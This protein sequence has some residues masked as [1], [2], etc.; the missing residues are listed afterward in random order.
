MKQSYWSSTKIWIIKIFLISFGKRIMNLTHWFQTRFERATW[1]T[2]KDK[3]T[4]TKAQELQ[5]QEPTSFCGGTMLLFSYFSCTWDH[6]HPD[7][8]PN[9]WGTNPCQWVTFAFVYSYFLSFAP[10]AQCMKFQ[11]MHVPPCNPNHP[12][13][14]KDAIFVEC[15]WFVWEIISKNVVTPTQT[16]AKIPMW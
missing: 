13:H 4:C 14:H 16:I 7:F 10:M 12:R 6:V 5:W 2:T 3:A 1:R 11:L 8:C 15:S 9:V